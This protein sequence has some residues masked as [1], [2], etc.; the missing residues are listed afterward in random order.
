MAEV[1]PTIKRGPVAV[2]EESPQQAVRRLAQAATGRHAQMRQADRMRPPGRERF[3][4]ARKVVRPIVP[5]EAPQGRH[6]ARQEIVA[7]G[8]EARAEAEQSRDR[9]GRRA[10]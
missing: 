10:A 5:S 9:V 3:D 7:R 1:R 2:A 4:S 6:R 8:G